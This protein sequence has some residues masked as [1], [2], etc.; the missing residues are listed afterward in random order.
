MNWDQIEGSGKRFTGSARERRG[1]LTNGSGNDQRQELLV[2][3]GDS[4]PVCSIA[5]GSMKRNQAGFGGLWCRFMHTEPMW[6]SHGQYE[7]RTCGRRF[8]V[9]WEQPSTVASRGDGIA[10]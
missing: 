4:G 7:C 9:C 6:P 10:A 3:R 2:G 8:Q 1:Q 5:D